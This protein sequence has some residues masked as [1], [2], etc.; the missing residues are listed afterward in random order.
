MRVT[1]SIR[2]YIEKEIRA[3]LEPKY[4][5][6]KAEA[7]R[8]AD[9]RE[10][11]LSGA[12][13]AAEAA[14]NAYID[15]HFPSIAEFADDCRK[16]PYGGNMPSFYNN[17]SLQIRDMSYTTSVHNWSRRCSEECK[18]K[19]EEIIVTLELGGTKKDLDEMLR[20]L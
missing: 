12:A 3:R 19:S 14:Y 8:Q 11:V 9:A 5:E 1:K 6:E 10:A 7:K 4:A 16:G 13:K 2:E 18:V 15:E 17:R 20:N